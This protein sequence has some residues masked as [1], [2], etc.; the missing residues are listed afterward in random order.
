MQDLVYQGILRES[1]SPWASP[2]V[3]VIKKD[4]SVRFC[5]DYR[6]L[7]QVTCKDE[8]PL[9]RVEDSLDALGGAQLFS[10]LDLMTVYFQIETAWPEAKAEQVLSIETGGEVSRSPYLPQGHSGGRRKSPGFRNLAGAQEC[11]GVCR[12]YS[13]LMEACWVL[14]A[15]LSQKQGGAERVTAYASR[16]LRGSEK[17]DKNYSE[18]KLELLSL[19]WAAT[20][21]FK[22][23]L[24]YSKFTVVTD[25]N[26]LRHLETANLGAVEQR[27]VAQLAE[28]NFEVCYKPEKAKVGPSSAVALQASVRKKIIGYSWAEI[29]EQQKSDPNAEPIYRA[30]MNDRRPTRAEEQ[31]MS[32]SLRQLTRQFERLRLQKGVLFRIILDS[33]DGEGISQLVVPEMLQRQVYESQHEHGGHFGERSTLGLMRR[34]YYWATMAK[35]VQ[36]WIKECKRCTLSKDMLLRT[37]APM[38]CTNVSAPLEVLAMDYTLLKRSAGGYENVLVLTDMFIRYTVAVPTKNQTAHTMARALMQHWFV[39]YGCP[40]RLHSDQGRCFEANVIKE[41]C[42]PYH[43]QG[44]SQCKRLFAILFNVCEGCHL[45]DWLKGHHERLR[46]AM[47]VAGAAAQEVSWRRKRAYDRKSWGALVRP[48]DRVLLRNH[49]QRG[50]NK[51]QDKWESAPYI[52]VK[53]NNADIPVYIISPEKGGPLKV[54]HRDQLRHCTFQTEPHLH[55]PRHRTRKDSDSVTEHNVIYIPAT[56]LPSNTDTTVGRRVVDEPDPVGQEQEVGSGSDQAADQSDMAG[57]SD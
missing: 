46:T 12:S 10:T 39:H 51:I 8:Y 2:A 35:D 30:V 25:H 20:E 55:T 21:K 44:N 9:P 45:D 47:E 11:E 37:R 28:Y 32:P 7:N 36:N 41:L 6:R 52:V 1:C 42:K 5:C 43:P 14:G 54:V 31:R 48:G 24:M 27:W 34:S 3:I 40:A 18:F 13:P 29:Q 53:Q 19:K 56:T 15:V 22:E 57:G 38:T 26:P 49:A 50:R 33:R 4:G 23:Y 17:N 16:G